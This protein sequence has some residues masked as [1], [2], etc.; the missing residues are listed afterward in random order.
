MTDTMP[1]HELKNS[2]LSRS[3]ALV[4]F[5]CLLSTFLPLGCSHHPESDAALQ[6]RLVGTWRYHESS[7][8]GVKTRGDLV[9]TVTSNGGYT[10]RVTTP[11]PHALAGTAEVKNGFLIVTVTNRDNATVPWPL[12]D[13]QTIVR[14]DN[15]LLV[16][17]SE[18]SNVENVFGKDTP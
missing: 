13:R 17:R 1:N 4:A 6:K 10:S 9:F 11:Q 15:E 16:T 18:G 12:V 7:G 5:I 8:T 3:T 14:F 2:P